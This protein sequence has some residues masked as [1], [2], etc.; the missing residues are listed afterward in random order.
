MVVNHRSAQFTDLIVWQKVRAFVLAVYTYTASFPKVECYGLVQQ[1][2][3]AVVSIPANIAEGYRR[4]GRAEK[5]GFFN[6]A[7]ASLEECRYYLIL[8]KDLNHGEH[9]FE[10]NLVEV[11]KLLTAYIRGIEKKGERS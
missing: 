6:I 2:R 10:D 4:R 5:V 11:S 7:Q 8:S 3:R 9:Q 1:F